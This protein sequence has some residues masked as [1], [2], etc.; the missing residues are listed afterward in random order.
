VRC[1]Q[2]Q[3]VF[4][5]YDDGKNSENNC[6]GN[7]VGG[8]D[9]PDVLSLQLVGG[10]RGGGSCGLEPWIDGVLTCFLHSL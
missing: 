8:F 7:M 3:K 2:E 9:E 10:G 1:C 5:I 6:V 4:I